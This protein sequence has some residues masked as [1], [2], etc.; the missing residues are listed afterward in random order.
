MPEPISG[1]ADDTAH[2]HRLP[3]GLRPRELRED[4]GTATFRHLQHHASG[5][6]ASSAAP[7]HGYGTDCSVSATRASDCQQ[8]TRRIDERR[9]RSGEPPNS[10]FR[11][12]PRRRIEMNVVARLTPVAA[13]MLSRIYSLV[14]ET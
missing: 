8:P 12:P 7:S 11:Y 1:D 5:R 4:R 10:S 2:Q 3:V 14:A 13:T 9:S 6:A